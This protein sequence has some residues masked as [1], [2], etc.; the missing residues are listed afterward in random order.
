MPELAYATIVLSQAISRAPLTWRVS[1]K[2]SQGR[3][4][5]L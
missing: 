2:V 5:V 4:D 3:F 1:A